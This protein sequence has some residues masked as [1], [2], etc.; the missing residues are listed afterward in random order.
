MA[1]IQV[2]RQTLRPSAA[3][4]MRPEAIDRASTFSDAATVKR[5]GREVQVAADRQLSAALDRKAIGGLEPQKV[6]L[7]GVANRPPIRADSGIQ[8]ETA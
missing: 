3:E 2:R 5:W 1:D 6:K 7:S 8:R 4:K